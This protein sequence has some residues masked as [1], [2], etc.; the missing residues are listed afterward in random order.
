LFI[1]H[2]HSQTIMK[3]LFWALAFFFSVP[4]SAQIQSATL[5]ASGLTCSMCS[6]AIFK[7]LQKV[8]SIQK[9]DVDIEKSEYTIA[10]KPGAAVVLDDVKKAVESA[11]FSVASLQVHAR[12]EPTTAGA[13]AH[14]N[15]GGNTVHFLNSKDRTISGDVTFSVV[16]KGYVPIA[17]H[18]AYGQFTNMK[19]FETGYMESCCTTGTSGK[20]PQRIY[21]AVL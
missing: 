18:K 21:H 2:K 10:F 14:I 6:K 9:V 13:D 8:S 11:G 16:D 5:K 17:V 1:F 20:A 4:A 3:H 19:C 12:L 7:S 15:L